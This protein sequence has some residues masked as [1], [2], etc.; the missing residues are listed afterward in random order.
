[1]L[2][3]NLVHNLV[4]YEIGYEVKTIDAPCYLAIYKDHYF[5]FFSFHQN[6]KEVEH[7]PHIP[8]VIAI[9]SIMYVMDCTRL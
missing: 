7:M 3:R 2:N 5:I 9:G 4:V 8:Y 1:M 6:E